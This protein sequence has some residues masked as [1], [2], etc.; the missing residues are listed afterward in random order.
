MSDRRRFAGASANYLLRHLIG[1]SNALRSSVGEEIESRG[2]HLK[3]S[4]PQVIV[5]LPIDGLG[6]S[7][8]ATRLRL[9]LQRTGQLVAQLEELGYVERVLD[10]SDGRAKRVVYTERGRKLLQDIDAADASITKEVSSVLGEKRFARLCR[11]LETLDREI[12]GPDD[13]LRL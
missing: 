12:N 11:D 13:V 5:N 10:E 3:A 9:T 4:T 1:V 6:L 2:H 7:E 8:L